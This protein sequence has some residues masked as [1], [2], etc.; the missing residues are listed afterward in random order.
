MEPDDGRLRPLPRFIYVVV[1]V[2]SF[3]NFCAFYTL[4]IITAALLYIPYSFALNWKTTSAIVTSTLIGGMIGALSG[5]PLADRIGRRPCHLIGSTLL[6]LGGVLVT[7]APSLWFIVGG[8]F[9]SGLGIGIV[10]HLVNLII[11][12]LVPSEKRGSLCTIPYFFQFIGTMCPFL[13]G[14]LIVLSLPS[15][16]MH[17]AWRLMV[18]SGVVVSVVDM[19]STFWWLPESPRWL[20][21]HAKTLEGLALME[22]IYGRDN[23]TRLVA[24]YRE[25]IAL[26][27]Q[28][29]TTKSSA[30]T[31]WE[32]LSV[33]KYRRPV[34]IGITLQII[35][36]LSGNAAVTFYLTLIL[37]ES[38]GLEKS[39]ALLV[40]LLIYIPDF[41]VSFGV[42]RLLDR[43]GRKLL[44]FVSCFG[45]AFAILPMAVVLTVDGPASGT[46]SLQQHKQFILNYLQG[47]IQSTTTTTL[48]TMSNSTTTTIRCIVIASLFAQRCFYSFGLGPVPS[49]HTAETLPQKIRAKGLGLALFFSWTAAAAATVAFPWAIIYLPAGCAYWFFCGVALV[50][51]P[52]IF[53]AVR[54]TANMSLDPI[55]SPVIHKPEPQLPKPNFSLQNDQDN[56]DNISL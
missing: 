12:E 37:V 11:V 18:G 47:S 40:S 30:A 26:Q 3:S 48:N 55:P 32:I 7:G 44:L 20:L 10:T 16:S 24:D 46:L 49:I 15:Q 34:L 56:F 36:K 31:W 19:F 43:L 50:G 23:H 1:T 6:L 38:A 51:T 2:A 22:R 54:E 17:L 41:V 27:Q 21:Y 35:R 39:T 25:I 4:G 13:V 45:L 29:D 28:S 5:G 33:P 53:F 52:F 42:F 8:R 9:V 14:Y